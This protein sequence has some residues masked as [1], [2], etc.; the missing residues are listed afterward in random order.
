LERKPEFVVDFERV[1]GIDFDKTLDEA[2][3][4]VEPREIGKSRRICGDRHLFAPDF[5]VIETDDNRNDDRFVLA[6]V[7]NTRDN[8]AMVRAAEG[9]RLVDDDAV[10]ADVVE[11]FDGKIHR[12][13]LDVG[14]DDALA[15]RSVPTVPLKVGN[16]DE[17]LL[18]A[19]EITEHAVG[20]REGFIVPGS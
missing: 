7:V 5:L 8:T 10:D 19:A 4:Q 12:F 20:K 13:R 6:V 3:A 11:I 1:I 18:I 16:D 17:L 14:A 9:G 2:K 15:A